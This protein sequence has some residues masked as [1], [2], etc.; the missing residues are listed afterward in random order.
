MHSL[1]VWES[2]CRFTNA[3]E[4]NRLLVSDVAPILSRLCSETFCQ[5]KHP[6][7]M[8]LYLTFWRCPTLVVIGKTEF[9]SRAVIPSKSARRNGC[10][11]LTC[12]RKSKSQSSVAPNFVPHMTPFF[13]SAHP[14][15]LFLLNADVPRWCTLRTPFHH[16]FLWSNVPFTASNVASSV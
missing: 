12:N 6:I 16:L 8:S 14:R 2:L 10:L 13:S 5:G 3:V 7:M 11:D 15:Q 9:P 4:A 1:P